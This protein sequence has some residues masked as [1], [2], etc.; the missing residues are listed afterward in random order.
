MYWLLVLAVMGTSISWLQGIDPTYLDQDE[1]VWVMN[2]QFYE[3]YM[4]GEW[5]SFRLETS[6]PWTGP[7]ADHQNQIVEQPQLAKLLVGASLAL[8]GHESWQTPYRQRLYEQFAARQISREELLALPNGEGETIL[9][10]VMALRVATATVGLLGLA[11]LGVLIQLFTKKW[12]SG[13]IVFLLLAW[14]PTVRLFLRIGVVNSFSFVSQLV[15]ILVLILSF[16]QL[17]PKKKAS[18]TLLRSS[19]WWGA[20]AGVLLAAATSIK[21]NGGFLILIPI[22][23]SF[24]VLIFYPKLSSKLLEWLVSMF[25]AGGLT[26]LLLEPELW[27]NPVA[28]TGVLL[29]SRLV[30]QQRF[31]GALGQLSFFETIIFLW[32]QFQMSFYTQFPMWL[33]ESVGVL[34]VA[35]GMVHLGKRV[36]KQSSFLEMSLLV[37]VLT[38]LL[39]SVWYARTGFDRYALPSIF[40]LVCIWVIGF[41]ELD[42]RYLWQEVRKLFFQREA[43]T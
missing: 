23:L 31:Y 5:Q 9:T 28:N 2:G 26:F 10:G 27:T 16:S 24:L 40:L 12:W 17:Q 8:Q 18:T 4:S 22:I 1:V 37:A 3:W 36:L 29:M 21:L 15:A 14:H 30:Q 7:W 19:L 41:A 42:M 43:N 20:G 25:I 34:G 13:S 6:E 33:S 39:S 11:L 38:V 32:R 35:L